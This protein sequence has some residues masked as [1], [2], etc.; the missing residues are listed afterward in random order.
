MTA[1]FTETVTFNHKTDVALQADQFP[2]WDRMRELHGTLLNT[3]SGPAP[4]WYLFGYDDVR[5]AFQDDELFSSRSVEVFETAEM[6]AQKKPWIPVEVDEPEHEMYRRLISPF[7]TPTAARERVDEIRQLCVELIDEL[8]PR[9]GCDVMADFAKR[10][11]TVIFMRIM[12]L[13]TDQADQFLEWIETMMHTRVEDDPDYTIRVGA[14]NA[15]MGYLGELIAARRTTPRD[16]LVTTLVQATV[17]GGRSL[18]DEELLSVCFLMYMAGLD[19][20][21]ASIGYFLQHFATHDADRRALAAGEISAEDAVEELLRTRS[22]VNTGRIVTRD[23]EFAGCPM[24]RG[25]RVVL[26]VAAANRDPAE[27][28]DASEMR[29]GRRPNRH[30][31]FGAGPHR[32]LGSHLARI[33][34]AVALEEWHRRIPEYRVRE[35][36]A[37]VDRP[38]SVSSLISLPLTW[39]V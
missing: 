14:R 17:D 37:I 19:T 25:D 5:A 6:I 22:V 33:E 15:V 8:R 31:A 39:Q 20:V 21:A 24:K 13:P 32:C 18:T 9:G 11:P 30:I 28:G 16:D 27:F 1:D 3:E 10:F 36:A 26:S 35:G 29:F 34:L 7:F 2:T 12:G 4:I 38:A 23:T